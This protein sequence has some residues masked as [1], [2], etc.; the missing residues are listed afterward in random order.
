MIRLSP[1]TPTSGDHG[2]PTYDLQRRAAM[3]FDT[4]SGIVGDPRSAERA[5]WEGQR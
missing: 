3:R 1:H 4:T 2:W 5:M